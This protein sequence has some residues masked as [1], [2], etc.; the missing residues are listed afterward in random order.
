MAEAGVPEWAKVTHMRDATTF[1]TPAQGHSPNMV[2]TISKH[3]AAVFL[4][5]YLCALLIPVCVCLAGF[6]PNGKKDKIYGK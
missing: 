2:E 4:Q 3:K 5:S 1:T 6:L